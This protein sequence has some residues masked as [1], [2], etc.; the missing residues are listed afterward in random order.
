MSWLPPYR[1]LDAAQKRAIEFVTSSEGN[2]FICGEA[3]TGKSVVLAYVALK[4]RK[5]HP[6][7]KICVLTYTKALV[8]CLDEELSKYELPVMTFHRFMAAK[9]EH[10]DCDL[11]LIDEAQDLQENWAARITKSGSKFVL[12]GDFAQM[13]YGKSGKII[14]E[15]AMLQMFAIRSSIPLVMDYR[16]PRSQ[17]E[18]VQGLYP[19]RKFTSKVYNLMRNAQIPLYHANGWDEEMGYIIKYVKQ[20]SVVRSQSAILFEWK[21]SIFKFF[22]TLLPELDGKK[23]DLKT[24]NAY[25]VEKN[26]PFRFL[27]NGEGDLTEGDKKPL[28]Y[29]MT[30]HSSKGLD[31]ETVVVPDLGFGR[32]QCACN[33]F[34]VAMTRARK[35]LLLTYS[36]K[37]TDQIE[38]AKACAS[39]CP[40]AADKETGSVRP[41]TRVVVQDRL[42]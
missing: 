16:L 29:V 21:R 27:G 26:I 5:D 9:G 22:Y 18:L 36:N 30:W 42:L 28:T 37:S 17:R 2:Y 13:I 12:F 40:I 31:F 23:I 19:D 39:V 34:Y 32:S 35:N 20:H 7:A 38:K 4:Y 10:K 6:D 15:E 41:R 33:P 14:T 3:G 8:A 25:L 11:I 24:I 1:K